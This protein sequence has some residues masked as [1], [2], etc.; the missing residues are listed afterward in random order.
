MRS[1]PGSPPRRRRPPAV[2]WLAAAGLTLSTLFLARLVLNLDLSPRPL[3][4]PP[5][6]LPLTGA[7]W[8]TAWLALSVGLWRGSG[9]A[10]DLT[11]WTIPAF[12]FWYWID[13][14]AFHR[15]DY[16]G[17]SRPAALLCSAAI[18]AAAF[19]VLT[20]PSVR[21]FFRERPDE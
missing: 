3:T 9:R 21:R 10:Y 5:G 7:I 4:V 12:A 17:V 18:A 15:S 11:F 6:Y 2:T 16:A 13:R 1:D 14:L 20:R 19:V 8:G